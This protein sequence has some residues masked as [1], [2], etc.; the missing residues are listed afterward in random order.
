MPVIQPYVDDILK[1]AKANANVN[2][3]A[4]LFDYDE[5]AKEEEA[6]KL[7]LQEGQKRIQ[8][9][10]AIGDALRLI[11][12]GV[13]G[14]MGASI[15]PRA[16]NPGIMQ[17]SQR[18][19]AL[20]DQSQGNM[21]RLRLQDL[22]MRE[23]GMTY[24]LGQDAQ[25][26]ARIYESNERAKQNKF[27]ESQLNKEL[28]SREKINEADNASMERRTRDTNRINLQK[29]QETVE[30]RA[31]LELLKRDQ[32]TDAALAKKGMFKVARYDNP[33][34]DV[35]VS[36]NQVIAL[37][38]ELKKYALANKLYPLP[39]ILQTN[40]FTAKVQDDQLKV[41]ISQYADFFRAKLPELSGMDEEIPQGPAPTFNSP[42]LNGIFQ[43]SQPATFQRGRG[44]LRSYG[45]GQPMAPA[46]VAPAVQQMNPVEAVKGILPDA[47][48]IYSKAESADQVMNELK[49][50]INTRYQDAS[51]QEK[52]TIYNDLIKQF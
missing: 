21:D 45:G 29:V 17:A 44:P 22:A 15:A 38:P 23:K 28:G 4:G 41:M 32:Q 2:P 24:K 14:S 52:A 34:E 13:T 42:L 10:N 43:Q 8:R 47:Q 30:G 50:L 11:S 1:V 5:M 19:N 49:A 3:Y 16:V 25:R 20:E 7:K 26:E 37:L 35:I 39:K 6:R 9:T 36:R 51:P 18:I 40:Q 33:Q 48:T 27:A 46:P 12:E 31:Q